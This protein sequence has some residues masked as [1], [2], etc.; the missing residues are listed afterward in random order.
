MER[1]RAVWKFEA[2][3]PVRPVDEPRA[4]EAGGGGGASPSLWHAAGAEGDC[5][6]ACAKGPDRMRTL[7]G[8]PR[9]CGP[10]DRRIRIM[11]QPCNATAED[12]RGKCERQQGAAEGGWH[13][14]REN[15]GPR[16]RAGAALGLFLSAGS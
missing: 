9:G 7:R 14:R 1:V 11:G 15:D 13:E 12:D 2:K 3:P 8:R 5:R 10:G 6:R 4:V 16:A